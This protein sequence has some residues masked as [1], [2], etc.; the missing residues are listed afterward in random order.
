[1]SDHIMM[2]NVP[3]A[4]AC[5]VPSCACGCHKSTEP[6]LP[7]VA[8]TAA[9]PTEGQV[10]AACI[11][12]SSGSPTPNNW[13]NMTERLREITRNRMRLALAAALQD[14]APRS[15]EQ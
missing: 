9:G 10:E 1:M 15:A 12:W 3:N 4:G 5:F 11:A 7:I 13:G 2:C 8:A 6:K 14:P